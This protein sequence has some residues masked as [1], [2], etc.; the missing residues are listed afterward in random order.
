MTTFIHVLVLAKFSDTTRELRVRDRENALREHRAE[1]LRCVRPA[2]A[3][4]PAC[5]GAC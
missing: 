4:F 5:P 3:L 1:S 2:H